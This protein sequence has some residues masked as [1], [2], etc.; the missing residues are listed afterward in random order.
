MHMVLYGIAMGLPQSRLQNP[1]NLSHHKL[2]Y[3]YL[4]L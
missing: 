1:H 2:L 3:T 4:K